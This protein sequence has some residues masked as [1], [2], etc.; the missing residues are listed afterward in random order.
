MTKKQRDILKAGKE[1]LFSEAIKDFALRENVIH[2]FGSGV[3]SRLFLYGV[4]GR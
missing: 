1:L 3:V 2:T 4:V